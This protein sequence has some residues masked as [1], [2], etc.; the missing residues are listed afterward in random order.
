MENVA[1]LFPT[2]M[3]VSCPV[4]PPLSKSGDFNFS[5]VVEKPCLRIQARF[6]K[7]TS[8]DTYKSGGI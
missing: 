2:G 6:V 7:T 3:C 4:F 1:H 8:K 5:E